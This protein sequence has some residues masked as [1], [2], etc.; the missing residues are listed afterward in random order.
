MWVVGATDYDRAANPDYTCPDGTREVSYDGIA[1]PANAVTLGAAET[2]TIPSPAIGPNRNFQVDTTLPRN[3]SAHDLDCQVTIPFIS[4]VA[5][6]EIAVTWKIQNGYAFCDAGGW[7]VDIRE[8]GG[9]W[10]SHRVPDQTT[11]RE[12]RHGGA[13]YGVHYEFRI[14]AVDARGRKVAAPD[15][16]WITT[17]AVAGRTLGG[18]PVSP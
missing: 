6:R 8:D 13:Q 9:D 12:Y 4:Q 11:N 7:F 17:S 18:A 15:A 3:T 10:G 16:A 5:I 14:R 1:F 2:W